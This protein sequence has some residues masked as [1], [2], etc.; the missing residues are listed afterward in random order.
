MCATKR[1][2]K[3]SVCIML[4]KK[5]SAYEMDDKKCLLLH[6]NEIKKIWKSAKKNLFHM[7]QHKT[8]S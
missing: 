8:K 5:E 2:K 7:K 3:F 1:V 4:S 6:L